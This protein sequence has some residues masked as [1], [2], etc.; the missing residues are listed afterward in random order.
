M[1][2]RGMHGVVIIH[3]RRHIRGNMASSGSGSSHV[4][5][6]SRHAPARQT[7]SHHVATQQAAAVATSSCSQSQRYC[8]RYF[9]FTISQ[10]VR[11]DNMSL[12]L[13][14]WLEPLQ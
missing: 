6:T 8:F 14:D 4:A 9:D 1:V 13:I 5:R 11:I 10:F 2:T 7:S 12:Q 3:W